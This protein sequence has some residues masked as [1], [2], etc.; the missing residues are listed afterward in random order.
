MANTFDSAL[1]TDSLRDVAITVLQ[2]RLAP[3][4]A[5]SQDF[6]ADPLKP[7]ATVQVPIATAGGT[8]QTNASNFESGD[9]TL[10]NVAVSVSQYSNS[11]HLT[12]DQINSGHRLEKIAKI[13]LHQLA[14][15]IID[16]ALAPVTAANFGAAT[17]DVDTAG[18]VTA[19][20][21]KT[22]WAAIK[23]GDS[24]NLIV[25]GSIYAQFLPA[26][27]DAFQLAAGGKNVGM[28]GF[29]FFSYNNRWDGA[30]ATVKGFACSPQAIAVASG[31]P[32]NDIAGSDMMAVENIEIP[33]LGLTVQMNM[34]VSRATR[35]VWASYDVMFGAAKGDP[36]ALKLIK[37]TP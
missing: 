25:D 26:N 29:D 33:D 19:A 10:D 14:N 11:F 8:T 12:N 34:W 16:V 21:L 7:R 15:K 1:V 35:A 2:S 17:I 22:L 13:N 6:S 9:S 4:N 24:R 27:L 23:D 5:F 30:E 32:A 3:L 28:Y 18:D 20:S 37:L 31:L 36:N